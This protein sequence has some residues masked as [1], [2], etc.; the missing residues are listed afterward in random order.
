MA[1]NVTI[2]DSAEVEKTIATKELAGAVHASKVVLVDTDGNTFSYSDDE[3]ALPVQVTEDVFHYAVHEGLAFSAA[4]NALTGDLYMCFTTPNTDNYLHLLYDFGG[5]GNCIFNV[6]EGCN[7]AATGG[8]EIVVYN[9]NR[10]SGMAGGG[11]S[12]VKANIAGTAG[13]V[14][15]GTGTFGTGGG[16]VQINPNGFMTGKNT[17]MQNASHEFV[18]E[19]NTTYG[20]HLDN[21]D[22]KDCGF[23]LTWFE[24]PK[25]A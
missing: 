17:S 11:A 19:K 21:T 3:I 9:K 14:Y 1:D 16:A 13:S 5:E 25:A 10:A 8:A 2:L 18:L 7:S 4:A 20:F 12:A 15:A 24:I 22:N 6:W 23:T